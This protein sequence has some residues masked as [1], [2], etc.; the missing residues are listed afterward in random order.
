M[1]EGNVELV[2]RGFL[3]AARGDIGVVTA[4]LAPGVRWHGAG[5]EHGG[6]QNR[7]QALRWMGDAI[8]RGIRVQLLETRELGDDRVLVLLQRNPP[9]DSNP[10]GQVPPP[11]GEILR[12]RDGKVTEMVVYPTAEDALRAAQEG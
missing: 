8:A 4:M 3:A 5:D 11:H 2:Q 12:F 6:C 10:G 7:E 1:A 9:P